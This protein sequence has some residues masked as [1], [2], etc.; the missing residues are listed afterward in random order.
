VARDNQ[1]PALIR[2]RAN[3]DIAMLRIK[4]LLELPA[5]ADLRLADT[6]ESPTLPPPPVF[7][8]RLAALELPV[9][10][11]TQPL[12]ADAP[13]PERTVVKEAAA[14]VELREA[15]LKAARA[16]GMPTA[17]VT[18]DYG[19]VAYPNGLLPRVDDFRSNWTI[20]ANVQFPLLTGGRVRAG[21]IVAKAELEQSLG[22]LKQ[23]T[24]LAELDSRS[25]RADLVAARAVWEASAGTV[26]QASRAYTIAEVRYRAGVSTQL[27]LS[28]SRLLLEQAEVNRAQAARD[29]QV[30]RAR[31]ALLPDLPL[32]TT[33]GLAASQT[34]QQ[35]PLTP[36]TPSTQGRSAITN[37]SAPAQAATQAG[38]LR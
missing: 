9:P 10:G 6:L 34:P 3:R 29:L 13:L 15:S 17:Q 21:R 8:P 26:E 16:E 27:E 22:Q 32:G 25:A 28:D 23:M 38:G 24:E 2:Q 1:A 4:Q 7:G 12:V 20:G 19:R 11:S 33:Q 31:M 5:D 37:A 30:A 18:S 35:T 14:L 36:A